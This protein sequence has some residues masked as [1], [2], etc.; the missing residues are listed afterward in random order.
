M[1]MVA[2]TAAEPL[3]VTLLWEPSEQEASL[4]APVGA[5]V[6]VQVRL[7]WPVKP[8]AGVT[9]M[10]ELPDEPILAIVTVLP[11][12]VKLSGTVAGLTVTLMF[13]VATV[14][15]PVAAVMARV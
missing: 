13:A 2:V 3:T 10:V 12:T 8:P 15:L 1:V 11:V 7:T 6:S 5:E 4:P 9:V 14:V